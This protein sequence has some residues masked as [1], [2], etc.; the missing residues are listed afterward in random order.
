[1]RIGRDTVGLKLYKTHKQA[2]DAFRMQTSAWHAGIAPPT[3][4]RVKVSIEGIKRSFYGY[5]TGQ[6]QMVFEDIDT[7]EDFESFQ[8]E[9]LEFRSL[10]K[11]V[12]IAYEDFSVSNVGVYDG[13]FVLVDWC[14]LSVCIGSRNRLYVPSERL[15][16]DCPV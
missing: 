11:R 10:V 15:R 2:S 6:A 7:D 12:G 3:I 5:L 13:R 1:M 4:S 16:H 14:P 9:I 8:R